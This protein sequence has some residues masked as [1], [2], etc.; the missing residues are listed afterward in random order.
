MMR[1]TGLALALALLLAL[2][3]PGALAAGPILDGNCGEHLTWELW[4]IGGKYTLELKGTGAFES[5][6]SF[7]DQVEWGEVENF[8]FGDNQVSEL[9]L[10]DG[11]TGIPDGTFRSVLGNCDLV[12]PG[13]VKTIGQQAFS[14]CWL[15]SVTIDEG[16]SAI[17]DE[18]FMYTS[19]CYPVHL[20]KSLTKIGENAFDPDHH[21][22]WVYKNSHAE[23][24]CKQNGFS[25]YTIG[26]SDSAY[27]AELW[28]T[29]NVIGTAD[30]VPPRYRKLAMEA[31]ASI[32][33]SA[34]KL[35]S[36]RTYI[37]QEEQTLKACMQDDEMSQ[38]EINGFVT[39]FKNAAGSL[40]DSLTTQVKLI[41]GFLG[42]EL[43]G[44][45][46]G[47]T[48]QVNVYRTGAHWYLSYDWNRDEPE[49][50]T[51]IAMDKDGVTLALGE[52]CDIRATLV[53]EGSHANLIWSTYPV[54][55]LDM[56]ENGDGS[57][58][59]T[60]ARPGWANVM[61]NSTGD[62]YLWS[63][64][65]VHVLSMKAPSKQ[66]SVLPENLKTI[67]DEAFA[68]T[69]FKQFYIPDGVTSIGSGA[70][71]N[72]KSLRYIWIPNSVASI[73]SDAFAG[74]T[75]VKVF[76][77]AYS[78]AAELLIGRNNLSLLFVEN[79]YADDE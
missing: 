64:C 74:C 2:G 70:F 63:E 73:A 55:T 77:S 45:A 26:G 34:A 72:C 48:Y 68:G 36:L 76:C 4:K 57:V 58:T 33:P 43:T 75:D 10:P 11:L 66:G 35:K 79:D 8:Y 47:K 25:Y 5:G 67:K 21:I 1:L 24:Y 15:S 62:A 27:E 44:T 78:L 51:D 29:L 65:S 37:A 18:A 32:R 61:V 14:G 19:G 16:V 17:D 69:S 6:F 20:P 46:G 49:T 42:V 9:I 22:L 13:S 59:I 31:L 71:R 41:N 28:E 60:G 3:C 30:D 50:A 39:R 38:A 23:S 12:I 40:F 53:P 7:Q 52:Q 56:V 54:G